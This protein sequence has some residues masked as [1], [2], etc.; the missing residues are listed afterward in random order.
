MN[1]Q[2][3]NDLPYLHSLAENKDELS[4]EIKQSKGYIL[5]VMNKNKIY[6]S[7]EFLMEDINAYS[8]L[9]VIKHYNLSRDQIKEVRT[10]FSY[11]ADNEITKDVLS[12]NE[13][14]AYLED[15]QTLPEN[16][17][18]ELN[19]IKKNYKAISTQYE[20]DEYNTKKIMS[21]SLKGISSEEFLTLD[22][23]FLKENIY[24]F[25]I[26][27]NLFKNKEYQDKYKE[28]ILKIAEEREYYPAL[29][30]FKNYIF[31]KNDK[32]FLEELLTNEKKDSYRMNSYKNFLDY[33]G[34]I[35][36]ISKQEYFKKYNSYDVRDFTDGEIKDN[37]E[38]IQKEFL[39]NIKKKSYEPLKDLAA[40][41]LS[42]TQQKL[43][44]NNHFMEMLFN[45]LPEIHI[46]YVD[47]DNQEIKDKFEQLQLTLLNYVVNNQTPEILSKVSLKDIAK[48][49]NEFS[50]NH[51]LIHRPGF[52]ENA[53]QF[54]TEVFPNLL[55]TSS[56]NVV[57]AASEFITKYTINVIEE[58]ANEKP[59][60]NFL[61]FLLDYQN[62]PKKGYNSERV[63]V[64]KIIDKM[65]P[66]LNRK[67]VTDLAHHFNYKISTGVILADNPLGNYEENLFNYK[68]T[69]LEDMSDLSITLLLNISQEFRQYIINEKKQLDSKFITAF[70][71][72][73][74]KKESMEFLVKYLEVNKDSAMQDE[75]LFRS[76]VTHPLGKQMM[77]FESQNYEEKDYQAFLL[78]VKELNELEEK[79]KPT[80]EKYYETPEYKVYEAKHRVIN[81]QIKKL[82]GGLTFDF[83]SEK[84]K[85]HL[86][87]NN[88][89][90]YCIL[91]DNYLISDENK[92]IFIKHVA[93]SGFN[94]VLKN[95]ENPCY[96]KM[97]ES[98]VDYNGLTKLR[99]KKFTE[100]ENHILAKLLSNQ[101]EDK[102]KPLI[103][104]RPE[105][106]GF[107]NEFIVKN[108]P[109]EMFYSYKLRPH[110]DKE[111]SFRMGSS[112]INNAYT[113]EQLIEGFNK[114]NK[115]GFFSVKEPNAN[116]ADIFQEN[117]K[118]REEQFKELLSV[119]KETNY[120][121][122]AILTNSSISKNFYNRSTVEMTQDEFQTNYLKNNY[123]IDNVLKGFKIIIDEINQAKDLNSD[124]FNSKIAFSSIQSFIHTTYHEKTK[125]YNNTEYYSPLESKEKIKII[126]F[127]FKETPYFMME[128]HRVG[129]IFVPT[130]I[131][132]NFEK[133]I[134]NNS[135]INDVLL[136]PDHMKGQYLSLNTRGKSNRYNDYVDEITVGMVDCFIKQENLD[137]LEYISYLIEKDDFNNQL[138][139]DFQYKNG[140]YNNNEI[141]NFVAT[142][143][144]I[145]E[146]LK[147]SK[148]KFSLET[149]LAEKPGHKVQTKRNKI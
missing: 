3:F 47:R 38:M 75:D 83:L 111:N 97:L 31:T 105:V 64:D 87:E 148:A 7:L 29:K 9:S 98:S 104:F 44:V 49:I 2:K 90:E 78:K 66:I 77:T 8:L 116:Y 51:M 139:Y 41:E 101:F 142:N 129:D 82:K 48:S 124:N 34:I 140:G 93:R 147:I 110:I 36:L 100:R 14:I 85:Q 53:T 112:L 6:P 128:Q 137:S 114:A 122:Y 133:Y 37:L 35:E 70:I 59:S 102:V 54:Y 149:L 50:S 131:A 103:F 46:S 119:S 57:Y 118:G 136:P 27:P 88:F 68:F 17:F 120:K 108:M 73:S 71:N 13:V 21:R 60:I 12:R 18:L 115:I 145:I 107:L 65:L 113:N 55:K 81:E 106:R 56:F 16:T 58:I 40:F 52:S 94:K 42:P 33:K 23:N 43:I 123:D 125:N 143:P 19:L 67:L 26:N 69:K 61:I 146:K 24:I 121:L 20:K 135:V 89:R 92:T 1:L 11:D 25:N 62:D 30:S 4:K 130:Y 134:D 99:F 132:E 74:E 39:K 95:I 144:E 96:I 79:E 32:P 63:R 126:D 84:I 138:S 28:L 45:K 141:L 72:D 5:H 86:K 109:L 10:Y 80:G 117:F 22:E 15:G 91:K 127:L 76:I